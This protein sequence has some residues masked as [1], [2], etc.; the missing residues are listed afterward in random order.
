MKLPLEF[1]IEYDLSVEILAAFAPNTL[2]PEQAKAKCNLYYNRWWLPVMENTP[3]GY[4]AQAGGANQDQEPYIAPCAATGKITACRTVKVRYWRTK[5]EPS[6]DTTPLEGKLI[7]VRGSDNEEWKVKPL[8]RIDHEGAW[9]RSTM[10]D[11][12]VPWNQYRFIVP[13]ELAN[14]ENT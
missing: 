14:E 5:A 6:D 10:C 12:D 2:T 7:L 13:S 11:I 3:D 9:T 4:A 8:R 1:H